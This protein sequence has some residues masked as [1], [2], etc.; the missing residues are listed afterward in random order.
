MAESIRDGHQAL[1]SAPDSDA[2]RSGERCERRPYEAPLIVDYGRV[3]D[4]AMGKG[5]NTTDSGSDTTYCY[6]IV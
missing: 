6:I 4:R 1:F 5:Y 2:E 3:A